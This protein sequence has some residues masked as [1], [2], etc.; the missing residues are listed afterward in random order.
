MLAQAL[1]WWSLQIQMLTQ[2]SDR[3][4]V[5]D[6]IYVMNWGNDSQCSGGPGLVM[7]AQ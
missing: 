5:A 3:M 4:K 6:Q 2:G 1:S 7:P